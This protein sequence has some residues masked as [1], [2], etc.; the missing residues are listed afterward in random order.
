[1]NNPNRSFYLSCWNCKRENIPYVFKAA[2]DTPP[3]KTTVQ[4]PC[5]FCQKPMAVEIPFDLPPDA[6]AIKHLPTRKGGE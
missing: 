6:T 5:P 3:G 2:E 1:M 4:V